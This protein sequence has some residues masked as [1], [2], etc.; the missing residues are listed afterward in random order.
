MRHFRH[1]WVHLVPRP[2][3][4]IGEVCEEAS[5]IA[6]HL[7][8]MVQF[9]F[10]DTKVV[11]YPGMIAEVVFRQWNLIRGREKKMKLEWN[12]GGRYGT[13]RLEESS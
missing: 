8:T 12:D 9:A 6:L 11:I 10:N 13:R 5:S 7:H 1:T 4:V 2:G 3:A